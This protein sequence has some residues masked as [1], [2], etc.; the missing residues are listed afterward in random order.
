M[1][2]LMTQLR[3]GDRFVFD[4][5][6]YTVAEPPQ[7]TWGIIEVWTEELDWPFEEVRRAPLTGK[8]HLTRGEQAAAQ[9]SGPTHPPLAARTEPRE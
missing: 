9:T 8:D 2:I 6:V 7:S 4:G 5:E 1:D 3:I